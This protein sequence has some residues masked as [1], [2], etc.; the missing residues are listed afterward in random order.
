MSIIMKQDRSE[1]LT[2]PAFYWY[3][4]PEKAVSGTFAVGYVNQQVPAA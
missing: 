3:T 4:A 1:K 2:F